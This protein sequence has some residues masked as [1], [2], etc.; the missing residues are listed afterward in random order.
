MFW[1][2][3]T[4]FKHEVSLKKINNLEKE[5]GK[6]EKGKRRKKR[7]EEEEEEGG[8]QCLKNEKKI[9]KLKKWKMKKVVDL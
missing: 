1:N 3:R 4:I 6:K 2:L 8:R 5:K 9:F 7:G